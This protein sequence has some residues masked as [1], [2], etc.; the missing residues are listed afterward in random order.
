[1]TPKTKQDLIEF[2]QA[3]LMLDKRDLAMVIDVFAMREVDAYIACNPLPKNADPQ[4]MRSIMLM[5]S[6]T[7]AVKHAEEI[8]Q[9]ARHTFTKQPSTA[10]SEAIAKAEADAAIIKA[11]GKL[12]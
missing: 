8:L 3:L 12:N 11:Q 9:K 1:M 4:D 7:E 10:G 2:H 6:V 5:V